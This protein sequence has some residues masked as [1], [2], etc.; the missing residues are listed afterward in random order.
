MAQHDYNISNATG[1]AFRGD[2]NSALQAVVTINSGATEPAV[3][4]AGMLWLDL[5]GGG[6]GV[7]RRRNQAN[8]AWLTDIGIDATA[9]SMATSAQTTANAALPRAG[10]T[11]TGPIVLPATEAL[12]NQAISRQWT[13]QLYQVRLPTPVGGSLLLGTAGGWA[14]TLAPGGD[15]SVLVTAGGLPQWQN[16]GTTSAPGI[17]V[18]TGADGTIDSSF[19]PQV[20]SGLRFCG[21]FRPA[22]N[23]EYPQSGGHGAGGVPAIGDFWVIDGLTTGGYTYL[24]GTLAGVTVYNGDSIAYN[25]AGS[26][27]RMGS[28][29]NLQ[30]Y[31]KTDG[32]IAMAGVLNMGTFGI[33]NVGNIAGRAGAQVNMTNFRLDQ[34]NAVLAPQRGNLGADLS[35]MQLGQYGTD[36]G[37]MQV[38]VGTGTAN[39]GMLPVRYFTEFETYPTG[40]YVKQGA[41][42]YR[43]PAAVAAGAFTLAQWRQVVDTGGAS[44]QGSVTILDTASLLFKVPG[45]PSYYYMQGNA[46]FLTFNYQNDAGAYVAT[47]LQISRVSNRVETSNIL[48]NGTTQLNGALLLNMQASGNMVIYRSGTVARFFSNGDA[49]TLNF[50]ALKDDGSYWDVPLQI[51]R[52]SATPGVSIRGEFRV[53]GNNAVDN[54]GEILFGT[55]SQSLLFQ[56]TDFVFNSPVTGPSFTPTCDKRIKFGVTS[57][58]PRAF[59]KLGW[60][61]FSRAKGGARERG[62]VAQ[63]VQEIAPDY[64]HEVDLGNGETVLA[65]NVDALAI[66]IGLNALARIRALEKYVEEAAIPQPKN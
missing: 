21:T 23:A 65:V 35:P 19:I 30:G 37:R 53:W 39:V 38:F 4:F 20:A 16:T 25:G 32:S 45:L 66:E 24:T 59:D 28:T 17:V 14:A 46:S 6:D 62:P 3:R 50:N 18:R 11:M 15:Q 63:E 48:N 34:T 9:R 2:L 1:A 7:M 27:F 29:V 49:G 42:Q 58:E 13:D 51:R 41:Y 44:F 43:A 56:G 64:V 54:R 47:P 40:E 31:L 10:G 26:W 57:A 5:S 12:G 52:T 33:N 61:D 55:G 36:M 22:V 60:H 8:S